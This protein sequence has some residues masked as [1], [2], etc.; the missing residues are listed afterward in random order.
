MMA[1]PGPSSHLGSVLAPP[2]LGRE[3]VSVSVVEGACREAQQEWAMA[4]G[5]FPQVGLVR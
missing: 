4:S 1:L 2:D 5:P 3:E